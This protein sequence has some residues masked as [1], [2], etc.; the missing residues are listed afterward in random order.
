MVDNETHQIFLEKKGG[1]VEGIKE[2]NWMGK[3]VQS[4][5]YPVMKISQ[6]NS[7]VLLLIHKYNLK[8]F[9]KVVIAKNFLNLGNEMDIQ[10]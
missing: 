2:Y 8:Y 9:N 1:K 3:L 5:L 7:L 10:V 4:T 6:C